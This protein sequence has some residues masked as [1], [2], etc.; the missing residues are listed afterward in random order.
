M[1]NVNNL[2]FF[3]DC[4]IEKIAGLPFAFTVNNKMLNVDQPT[5]KYD[6]LKKRFMKKVVKED[7]IQELQLVSHFCCFNDMNL[8][9]AGCLGIVATWTGQYIC[10]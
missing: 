10:M 9:V 5:P 2:I 4:C 8:T 3:G 7:P 1:R 6:Q